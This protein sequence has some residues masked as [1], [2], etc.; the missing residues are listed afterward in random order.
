MILT[1][2]CACECMNMSVSVKCGNEGIY[3]CTLLIY[4]CITVKKNTETFISKGLHESHHDTIWLI[5]LYTFKTHCMSCTSTAISNQCFSNQAAKRFICLLSVCHYLVSFFI[6]RCDRLLVPHLMYLVKF[7]MS[8]PLSLFHH[9]LKDWWALTNTQQYI[10]NH[11]T[12]TPVTVVTLSS[13]NM[14]LCTIPMHCM[15]TIE[16]TWFVSN[17]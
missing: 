14:M 11:M 6:T 15:D 1:V 2:W 12:W 10:L 8:L 3:L 7:F 5:C 16:S 9:L 13:G 4:N 17:L